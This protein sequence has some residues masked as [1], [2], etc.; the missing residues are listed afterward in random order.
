MHYKR[1]S[2]KLRFIDFGSSSDDRMRV[3]D[4]APIFNLKI[5]D[6]IICDGSESVAIYNNGRWDLNFDS[7]ALSVYRSSYINNVIVTSVDIKMEIDDFYC[8][9]KS[10]K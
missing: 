5:V 1:L 6:N 3:F 9:E 2:H 8:D 4:T 10:S 7:K